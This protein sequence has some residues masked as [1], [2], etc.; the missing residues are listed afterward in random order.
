[1]KRIILI[2][3]VAIICVGFGLNKANAQTVAIIVNT[4][5]PVEQMSQIEVKLYYMRKIKQTWPGLGSVII[6]VGY[7]PDSPFKQAFLSQ[8]MKM[9]N[10]AL[11]SYFKQREFANAETIPDQLMSEAEVIDYV[12]KN[13]GAIGYVSIAALDGAKNKVKSV[14]T[15]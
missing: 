5:N 15:K 3:L 8:I 9:S 6:P 14:L 11:D 7:R 13:T 10:S 1:M 2:S 4:Q 12:S